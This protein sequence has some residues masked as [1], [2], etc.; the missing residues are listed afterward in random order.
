MSIDDVDDLNIVL[1]AEEAAIQRLRKRN[2]A[3][4]GRT[5]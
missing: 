3:R 1:N 5:R 4:S 2:E